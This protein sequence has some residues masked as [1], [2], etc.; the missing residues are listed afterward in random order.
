MHVDPSLTSN[1]I[2]HQLLR[3]EMGMQKSVDMSSILAANLKAGR[4]T[5]TILPSDSERRYPGDRNI[6]MFYNVNDQTLAIGR[7]FINH[8]TKTNEMR[9]KIVQAGTKQSIWSV[10]LPSSTRSSFLTDDYL[11]ISTVTPAKIFA[12]R[13]QDGEIQ[14]EKSTC[15]MTKFTAVGKEIV[16]LLQNGNLEVW[17]LHDGEE[18]TVFD[19]IK[20]PEKFQYLK[21][22]HFGNYFVM[23]S[24]NWVRVYNMEKRELCYERTNSGSSL[25]SDFERMV[26]AIHIDV[27]SNKLAYLSFPNIQVVDLCSKKVVFEYCLDESDN[28]S[29]SN[30]IILHPP[31][32]FF[33]VDYGSV[34]ALNMET[35]DLRNINYCG[36]SDTSDDLEVDSL[37]IKGKLLLVSYNINDEN[38]TSFIDLSTLEVIANRPGRFFLDNS[39]LVRFEGENI[40]LDDY[41]IG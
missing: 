34:C 22:S 16:V 14:W 15:G 23:N 27:Q 1:N 6:R 26:P 11:L 38:R 31:Y 39:T 8:S 30:N 35:K 41:Q 25:C 3:R 36:S 13:L 28:P 20:E 4:H 29:D 40:I 37:S 5:K 7:L 12:I 21:F 19:V 2:A 9:T 10:S 18:I 24:S 17:N 33:E 32:L